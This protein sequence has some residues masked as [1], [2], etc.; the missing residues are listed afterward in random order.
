MEFEANK[1]SGYW[2]YLFVDLAGESRRTVKNG[3]KASQEP[4]Q[5]TFVSK[6]NNQ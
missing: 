4:S 6:K 5:I 2:D 1:T 3:I